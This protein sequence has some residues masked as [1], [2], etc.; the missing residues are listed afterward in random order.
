MTSA[1]A[2]PLLTSHPPLGGIP[3]LKKKTKTKRSHD[4]LKD[5]IV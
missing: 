2:Q 1:W 4:L 5:V 3:E